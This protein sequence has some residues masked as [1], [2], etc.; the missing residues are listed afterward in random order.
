MWLIKL[1]ETIGGLVVTE[2]KVVPADTLLEPSPG[3]VFTSYAE[4]YDTDNRSDQWEN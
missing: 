3:H 1:F 4:W 2:H